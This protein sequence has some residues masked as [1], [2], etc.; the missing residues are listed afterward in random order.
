MI[1]LMIHNERAYDKL[2][3]AMAEHKQVIYI[4]GVGTGK[5]FVM[6][7]FIDEHYKGKKCL[8]IA[9]A[10]VIFDNL[11]LYD[12]YKEIADSVEYLNMRQ[13]S[14]LEKTE[15]ILSQYDFVI[16]DEAHHLGSDLYG[17]NLL[18][19]IR[20]TNIP[21]LGLTATPVREDHTD[22]RDEFPFVVDGITNFDAIRLGL[23]P[24][25]TYRIG[26]MD[27]NLKSYRKR[28][29]REEKLKKQGIYIH[30]YN[31]CKD[32][33]KDIAEKFPRKKYITYSKDIASVENDRSVIEYAFPD[34]PIWELHTSVDGGREECGRIIREFNHADRGILMSVDMALEGN[35]LEGV[36]GII[37]MR[38]V[39]SIPLFQQMLG[40]VCSIGRTVSP[41][42]IDCSARGVELLAKLLKENDERWSHMSRLTRK[43]MEELRRKIEEIT[44][45][46]RENNETGEGQENTTGE[47]SINTQLLISG[48]SPEAQSTEEETGNPSQQNGKKAK[49]TKETAEGE[50]VYTD[51]RDIMHIALG[52][53]EA[54]EDVKEFEKAWAESTPTSHK[55]AREKRVKEAVTIWNNSLPSYTG[56]SEKT[57]KEIRV[58]IATQCKISVE[59][60]E[61]GIKS[62]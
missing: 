57:L 46:S 4:S 40:R 21:M 25:F 42:V 12:D 53:H 58:M 3:K 61:A 48:N 33:I 20:K 14:T 19:A 34:M 7:K 47:S 51:P 55:N 54:W 18:Q 35:H 5:S 29:Q 39:Q 23:M 60:M 17:C 26:V 24:Q 36:D 32:V 45:V 50:E 59:E 44:E 22:I 27:D 6:M 31:A 8:Y 30:D 2:C 62:A 49:E 11:K 38:N 13:F 1:K 56:L 28:L 15:Q 41:V 52:G 37:L 10:D 16:F 43:E 9:P